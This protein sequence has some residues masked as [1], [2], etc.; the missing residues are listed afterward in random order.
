M[1]KYLVYGIL[2]VAAGTAVVT[3]ANAGLFG[4]VVATAIV[5]TL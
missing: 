4:W 5:L 3:A 2:G 1:K